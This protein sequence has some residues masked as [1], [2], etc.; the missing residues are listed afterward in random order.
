M[1]ISDPNMDDLKDYI[2]RQASLSLET[3]AYRQGMCLL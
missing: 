1:M 3:L 2:G